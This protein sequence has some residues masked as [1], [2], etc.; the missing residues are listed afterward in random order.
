[1]DTVDRIR[2]SFNPN[3]GIE[4]V[5]LTMYDERTNL[6]QAVTDELKNFFGDRLCSTT[7]PRNVRLAE[8]PSHG[9]PALVYDVRSRGAES[10]IRLAKELMDRHAVVVHETDEP[11]PEA[12]P[13]GNE[14]AIPQPAPEVATE[15]APAFADGVAPAPV[16]DAVSAARATTEPPGEVEVRAD[17]SA[18]VD[19]DDE[20]LFAWFDPALVA[21]V[22][23]EAVAQARPELVGAEQHGA[24]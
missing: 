16:A 13:I 10:Y 21:A 18:A 4:G 8:A 12:E 1:M 24:D 17:D 3:L 22:A 2:Q 7:I 14:G 5:V 15:E 9:K 19:P 20:P 23:A 11:V 6:A